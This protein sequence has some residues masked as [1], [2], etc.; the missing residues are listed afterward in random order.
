M[1]CQRILIRR[2]QT[3]GLL[4]SEI[5]KTLPDPECPNAVQ[6]TPHPQGYNDHSRWADEMLKTHD[7]Q[8]CRGCGR[9]NI[10][11]PREQASTG[12]LPGGEQRG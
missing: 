12:T 6:H 9:W 4:C 1:T 5:E 10:W 7:Q 11:T 3:I 8:Q 2:D